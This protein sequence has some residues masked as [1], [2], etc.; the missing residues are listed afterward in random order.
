YDPDFQL[1][2]PKG[3]AD[4]FSQQ[5]SSLPESKRVLFREH[6][7]RKGDTLGIVAKKYGMT[8]AQLVSAN[9]LGKTPALKVGQTLVIPISGVTP[10]PVASKVSV[11]AS[12]TARTKPAS[13]RASSSYTVR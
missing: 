12:S 5:I 2:L 11:S 1:I 8:T 9:N 7:V 6:V 10:P 4:K 3:Y 13:P